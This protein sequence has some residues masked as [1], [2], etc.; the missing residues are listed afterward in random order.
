MTLPLI[1]EDKFEIGA[2]VV[3][4][5]P[6]PTM[7]MNGG[8]LCDKT[9]D[10]PRTQSILSN[11]SMN[12]SLK[13]NSKQLQ[14]SCKIVDP[15]TVSCKYVG[16]V[17]TPRFALGRDI[18]QAS[19][20]I[21]PQAAQVDLRGT[22]FVRNGNINYANY[23]GET[24]G[25]ARHSKSLDQLE[26]EHNCVTPRS[27]TFYGRLGNEDFLYKTLQVLEVNKASQDLGLPLKKRPSSG[28]QQREDLLK[29]INE[30]KQK[31]KNPGAQ[32]YN[33]NSAVVNFNDIELTQL[34][35]TE[36][37]TGETKCT[38][39]LDR[40]RTETNLNK[41][42]VPLQ[43]G[44]LRFNSLP[45]NSTINGITPPRQKRY[46]KHHS[47]PSN[48]VLSGS[49]S[50]L[51][52]SKSTQNIDRGQK[53]QRS[54]N[55][56]RYSRVRI[57]D[58]KH[59]V[60]KKSRSRRSIASQQECSSSSTESEKGLYERCKMP[61]IKSQKK[62]LSSI[63]VPHQL[64]HLNGVEKELEN[65]LSDSIPS[66]SSSSSRLVKSESLKIN[67]ERS[68]K[69]DDSQNEITQNTYG[70]LTNGRRQTTEG[71]KK[72]RA[73]LARTNLNKKGSE[74]SKSE[75][76]IPNANDIS[77]TIE[78]LK[79]IPPEQFRDTIFTPLPPEEF[80]D[81]DE[82]NHNTSNNC[83]VERPRSEEK[84]SKLKK[85]A[86]AA[87][88]THNQDIQLF[89][90]QHQIIKAIQAI[91]NPLYHM[92]DISHQIQTIER[93]SAKIITKSLSSNELFRNNSYNASRISL[94][95]GCSHSNS[96][97]SLKKADALSI[98]EHSITLY[99]KTAIQP[100]LLEF[101]KCREEF[102]KQVNYM[103]S[104]YSDFTKLASELPY[105]YIS[106]ELRVFS[107]K[108]LHL[109]VCVH[110]M[111]LYLFKTKT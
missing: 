33:Y 40:L 73:S 16:G 43:N 21:I 98:R 49:F 8:S 90:Q 54:H 42:P 78:D 20:T 22:H 103:G 37:E 92:C 108:G 81:S 25:V 77:A 44:D 64:E 31:Y 79:L 91:D 34:I 3:N 59:S 14:C 88:S 58:Y 28:V 85:L 89:R 82:I 36:V 70:Y 63:S 4:N 9:F 55:S 111:K 72:K 27:E 2:H 65:N 87:P 61:R 51:P 62:I 52:R 7:A 74:K 84:R 80:R 67:G 41:Y 11:R 68:R 75:F 104:I 19:L 26:Q 96:P 93:S 94:N 71:V 66:S 60:R 56:F 1:F 38:L 106:D 50:T 48:R 76:D 102:R 101:E 6:T 83:K 99:D 12:G 109:I 32:S 5:E 10:R 29:N 18:L 30:F 100:P 45:K 86:M 69:P 39:T 57:T 95:N 97:K 15:E 110:G 47:T 107:P 17:T 13:H 35:S 46:S 105:F 24:C 53:Q 23:C